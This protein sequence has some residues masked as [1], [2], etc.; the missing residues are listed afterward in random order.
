M[1]VSGKKIQADTTVLEATFCQPCSIDGVTLP[2]EAFCTICQEFMC[3]GCA[4]YHKKQKMLRSHT[5]LDKSRMPKTMMTHS[6]E[7]SITESCE[8][9]PE[10]FIKYFCVSHQTPNCGH[11]SIIGHN[12][13]EVQIISDICK[14]FKDSKEY[15]NIKTTIA[16]LLEDNETCVAD[17]DES[18][19]FVTKLAED[20]VSKLTEYGEKVNKY[21]EERKKSLL[22][23]I[24]QM[25]NTNQT[26]FDSLIPKCDTIRFKVTYIKSTLEAQEKNT[27][28]LFIETKRAQKQLESLQSVLDEINKEMTIHGYQFEKDPVTEELLQT[29]TG[30]G[31]IDI[32]ETEDSTSKKQ[33]KTEESS[34]ESDDDFVLRNFSPG[35]IASKNPHFE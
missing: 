2:A 18:T 4:N 26:L 9:H 25:K 33:E 8:T 15:G 3:S 34:E 29:G 1:E 20:Q 31:T 10:E 35:K 32:L 21:F 12:S 16:Q 28:K 7:Q 13:C 19:K 27:A 14:N 22:T 30:L 23:I 11:C 6:D 24:E 5:L 17:I